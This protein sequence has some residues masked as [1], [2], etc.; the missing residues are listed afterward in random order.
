VRIAADDCLGVLYSLP[1]GLTPPPPGGGPVSIAMVAAELPRTTPTG[2]P[3]FL[4]S[5]TMAPPS[6]APA[7]PMVR[8]NP[9]LDAALEQLDDPNPKVRTSAENAVRYLA[10]APDPAWLDYAKGSDVAER[11]RRVRLLPFSSDANKKYD[12]MIS[13][14]RETDPKVRR[15]AFGAMRRSLESPK[16][17][18]R[19]IAAMEKDESPAIR[20]QAA[21]TLS[22]V[23][24]NPRPK[25]P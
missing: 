7:Q 13:A 17:V 15:A 23:R 14:S 5:S 11:V 24:D 21:E 22:A 18:D 19:L 9:V 1:G 4:G 8:R 25:P 3:I 12:A 16:I 2:T 10:P 20:I 6:T